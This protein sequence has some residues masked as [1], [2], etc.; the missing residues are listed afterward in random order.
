MVYY[1]SFRNET[2]C[3]ASLLLSIIL[4]FYKKISLFSFSKK[5]FNQEMGMLIDKD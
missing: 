5:P 3:Q 1:S 2:Y 4:I